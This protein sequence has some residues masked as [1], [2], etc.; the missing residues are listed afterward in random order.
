MGKYKLGTTLWDLPFTVRTH[1]CLKAKDIN[2]FADV[3]KLDAKEMTKCRNFGKKCQRELEDFQKENKALY[4]AQI[5]AIATD[6]VSNGEFK[7]QLM[8]LILT[9]VTDAIG[10]AIE[11]CFTSI[12]KM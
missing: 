2:T 4:N 6:L 7:Q 8:E 11:Q 9:E 5:T 1:N 3:M 12:N 10:K